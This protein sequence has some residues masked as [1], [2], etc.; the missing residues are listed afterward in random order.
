MM[1]CQAIAVNLVSCG[2]EG[3][4]TEIKEGQRNRVVKKHHCGFCITNILLLNIDFQNCI[5]I[6]H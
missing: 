3:N 2:S 5:L 4:T 1:R 6:L